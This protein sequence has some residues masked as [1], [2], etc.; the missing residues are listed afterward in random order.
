MSAPTAI[1][2]A[3]PGPFAAPDPAGAPRPGDG[4]NRN[5]P[6]LA[7]REFAALWWAQLISIFGDRLTYLA[8]VGLL[9][10][11]TGDFRDARAP[12]LLS[13]LANVMLAPVLLFSPFAGAWVDRWRSEERR[14][15]KE[16]RL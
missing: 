7:Q 5:R 9:A 16:C 11:H 4:P 8:L 15:G 13:V 12:V 10:G 2:P 3:G 14:V 6:L 1:P